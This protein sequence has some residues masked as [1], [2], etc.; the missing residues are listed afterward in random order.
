MSIPENRAISQKLR[1]VV[2]LLEE[3]DANRFR[4]LAYRRAAETLERLDV[5]IST[6]VKEQGTEGLQALPGIGVSLARSIHTLVVTGQLPMLDRLRGDLDPAALLASIPGIGPAFARRLHDDLHIHTLEQLE[7]AAHDG[8]LAEIEGVG[9]KKLQGIIDS[10]TARLGRVRRT[11][12]SAGSRATEEPSIEELLE[13]DREYRESA[14]AGKLQK[15]APHR[16]NPKREAWLPILHTQRGARHYT[17]LFSNSALAHQLKKTRDWV[18][19]Y[20]DDDQGERQCTV[21]TARGAPFT[22]KRIV[23]GRE[24]D[25][26]AYYKG[27]S[28]TGNP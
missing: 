25:C 27:S 1:E 16:F 11:P 26:A 6:I 14:L 3:Q 4:I 20:Y 17:A 18:I 23:R 22:G 15:I 24:A 19:L 8:R 9:P 21:I 2:L 28:K 5:P 13:V 7:M 12:Q 10:L